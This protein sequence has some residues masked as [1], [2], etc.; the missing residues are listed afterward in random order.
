MALTIVGIGMRSSHLT[1]EAIEAIGRAEKAYVDAYTG[2]YEDL[3]AVL[4]LLPRGCEAVMARRRDLEGEGMLRVIE[5]A[6]SREVVV[7]VPGDPMVATTHD[8]LRAEALRR[9][10][11]VRLVN[12]LSVLQL[13]FSRAGLSSYRIGRAVT[14][15]REDLGGPGPAIEAIYDNMARGLHTLLLLDLRIE[16]GVFMDVEEAVE[17]IEG[18]DERGCVARAVAVGAAR[19]GW[20]DERMAADWL[21]NLPSRP[22]PPPPHAIVV[23]ARPGPVE[24][25]SL[26]LVAG[27]PREVAEEVRASRE[28]PPGCRGLGERF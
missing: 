8:A 21:G 2:L 6:R 1:R 22:L 11:E 19:L 24:L 9:G 26:E 20:S 15:V 18:H 7:L 5:E 13:A 3:D 4:S 23:L 25:E 12:G 17:L 14:L 10:V 16:E 28:Y 27:L